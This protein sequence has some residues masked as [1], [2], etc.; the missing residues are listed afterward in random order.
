M[1][2]HAAD[3]KAKAAFPGKNPGQGAGSQTP[4]GAPGLDVTGWRAL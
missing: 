2:T 3:D 4:V 1:N